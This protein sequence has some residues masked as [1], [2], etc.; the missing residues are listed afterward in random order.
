MLTRPLCTSQNQEPF[1]A[2]QFN[3]HERKVHDVCWSKDCKLFA[4]SSAD[5]S[6]RFWIPKITGTSAYFKAH[7]SSVRSVDLDASCDLFLTASDDKSVKLWQLGNK[8][9]VRIFGEHRN[10]VRCARFCPYEPKLIASCSEDKSTRVFNIETGT[11][12]NSFQD[13]KA[14]GSK[15]AWHAQK[16]IATAMSDGKVR[17]YDLRSNSLAQVYKIHE[18]PVNSI[19]FHPNGKYLLTGGEDGNIKVLDITIARPIYTLE[20]HTG[21][22]TAVAFNGSGDNFASGGADKSVGTYDDNF[23]G[24]PCTLI[25]PLVFFQIKICKTNFD[26][27]DDENCSLLSNGTYENEITE[28]ESP[29]YKPKCD[30]NRSWSEDIPIIQAGEE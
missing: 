11:C 22:V 7:T 14:Y 13:H 16:I 5:G 24:R 30:P 25:L 1:R 2:I 10:F 29:K 20:L 18:G 9:L 28:N 6:V 12:E 21:P 23:V 17:I 3:S 26:A 8:K 19:S 27:D 4:S 15:L